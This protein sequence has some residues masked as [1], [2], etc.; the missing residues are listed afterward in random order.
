MITRDR[1]FA[2]NRSESYAAVSSARRLVK[3]NRI[4]SYRRL[5][6]EHA[7]VQWKD[8]IDN[9]KESTAGAGVEPAPVSSD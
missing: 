6:E 8:L 7:I 3:D 4:T 5:P 1:E 2:T 9:R